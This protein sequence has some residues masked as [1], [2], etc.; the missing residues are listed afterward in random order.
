MR[1]G[2][3]LDIKLALLGRCD[4]DLSVGKTN[5]GRTGQNLRHQHGRRT[6]GRAKGGRLEYSEGFCREAPAQ[7]G[8][9]DTIVAAH[10][11]YYY[12]LRHR[13]DK[14]LKTSELLAATVHALQAGSRHTMRWYNW[15]R[16]DRSALD[17]VMIWP[18]G[19]A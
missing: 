12:A 14:F 8:L 7:I 16:L 2:N 10:Q 18:R 9:P 3:L 6:G 1:T 4:A 5:Y 13:I 19:V 15:R 17:G 11:G